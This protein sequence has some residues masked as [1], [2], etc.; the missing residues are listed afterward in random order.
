[1]FLPLSEP[2]N[3][4][5]SNLFKSDQQ[6]FWV[7][8]LNTQFISS[9]LWCSLVIFN[10]K[11]SSWCC[12]NFVLKI[13]FHQRWWLETISHWLNEPNHSWRINVGH[14]ARVV[15]SLGRI[16]MI[17]MFNLNSASSIGP[18]CP[19][20]LRTDG[21][22]LGV[23]FG[24]CP[25]RFVCSDTSPNWNVWNRLPQEYANTVLVIIESHR[26]LFRKQTHKIEF[27]DATELAM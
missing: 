17:A 5:Y 27:D 19:G 12:A 25:P 26:Q 15:T 7:M 21:Q 4:A 20:R 13:M 2:I 23:C 6:T 9:R 3:M 16:N 24:M 1:M 14:V 10:V 11:K 22:W 8:R 18:V